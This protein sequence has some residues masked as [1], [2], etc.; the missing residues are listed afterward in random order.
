MKS[1][2]RIISYTKPY[3]K[4]ILLTFVFTILFAILNGV[5]VYLTIP[6]LDT[7]F[8]ESSSKQTTEQTSQIEK[9]SS[10]LPDWIINLKEDTVKAF[11]DFVLAGDKPEVLIKICL[12]ILAAF[13]LKNFFG[14]IQGYFMAFVEYASMKDLRDETYSHL[15]KLPIGY[16]KSE[17]VGNIISRF[18]NDV[19]IIQASISATFSNLIKE[20]LTLIVFLA[21]AVSISWRLSLFAFIIVPIASLII[22]WI[23]IKLKK[24]TVILQS[25]IADI[26]SILQETISGVKIVKAFGMEQFEN[27]RFMNETKNYFKL[28]LKIVRTRNLSSPITEILSVIIGVVIIYYGG[29]LVLV[30]KTLNASE[31]LGFLFAIFQM[32]T[33][34]KE[35]GSVNN[36]IQ[37]ASAAAERVFEIIDI[38]PQIKNKP[39][40][41][42]L[43]SFKDEIVFKNIS[44]KYEDS[45][46][47][48]LDNLNFSVK[49]GE[50]LALVGPSGGGKST[51]ADLI[52]RFYDPTDGQILIDG[53][54][55]KDITIES[56]RAKMGIVT[57]E[58][59]LFNTNIAENIAYGLTD[60]PMEKIIEAAKTANAH[61]F[62]SEMPQGYKTMIGERGVKLSGGQRQRLTIA[63]ALLKNPDIMI[64]DEATSA[65]DNESEIL[66]QEA[67]ER[68]MLNRTTIVIAHRLST[69]R[70]AT[71][72]LVLNKGRIIQQGTHDK[73]IGDER[74]LYKKLY[75]M[76]FR[77]NEN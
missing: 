39:N 60:Y 74:G 40:A 18:T 2:Y 37:E 54:N 44:F 59:F 76:Q 17:R 15:H 42:E 55:I 43:N 45:D 5:S 47:F 50:I 28:V 71:N 26:T 73:L 75:E 29:V 11:N 66:V 69:I 62:I 34:I 64:F 25:K 3:W 52:P 51:L 12:L 46:V 1:Y 16:F 32:M 9:A 38:E 31:F 6:L 24:Q 22:A 65:L 70:N 7:L 14:Y 72:I 53:N 20:P 27:I 57:Q 21:I 23:G 4:H 67:I 58:T 19:N 10:I 48:V 61:N 68:L 49:R 77:D 8:Q 56:L 35:L 36:R 33:P 63:R 13:I 41:L 30:D